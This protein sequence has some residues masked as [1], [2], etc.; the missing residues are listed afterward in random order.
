M[1]AFLL[2]KR[3]DPDRNAIS[4]AAPLAEDRVT[5]IKKEDIDKLE[6]LYSARKSFLLRLFDEPMTLREAFGYFDKPWK[7]SGYAKAINTW[8]RK[9]FGQNAIIKEFLKG[10]TSST[11]FWVL[12]LNARLF[13]VDYSNY[14]VK[15]KIED[16][17]N[18]GIR[19]IIRKLAEL[20][21]W[22]TFEELRQAGIPEGHIQRYI[23]LREKTSNK[24]ATDKGLP[25]VF[26]KTRTEPDICILN[27]VFAEAL[28]IK[29]EKTIDLE[30]MFSPLDLSIIRHL[31]E[32]GGA[33]PTTLVEQCNVSRQTIF[34]A[35][36][37]INERC[38]EFSL[39][40]AIKQIKIGQRRVLKVNDK[41]LKETGLSKPKN[42]KLSAFFS[43]KQ[44]NLIK[45][46]EEHPFSNTR[47]IASHL[48]VG[49]RATNLLINRINAICEK[50]RL[51]SLLK[52]GN[53]YALRSEFIT[54]FGLRRVIVEP[55][56]VL[57]AEEQ[58]KVYRYFEINRI[59]T[60]AQA[61]EAIGKS[62]R[63]TSLL[64]RSANHWL[65][66]A[67]FLPILPRKTA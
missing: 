52:S 48:G 61:A 7:V 50:E 9:R 23:I 33:T 25:P 29:I 56:I 44:I 3:A 18:G 40:T 53:T 67:G 1:R 60:L 45:F 5:K 59:A 32:T 43:S 37:R 51:P 64:I 36:K 12:K 49:L 63:A 21:G 66:Q 17:L 47:Q 41:F 46:L 62:Y 30:K 24:Q 15:L 27:P 6:G 34:Q 2:R 26:L 58:I 31:V 10:E 20:G 22:A 11:G 65:I 57:K 14:N 8:A 38:R 54:K 13:D 28:K 35:I 42:L 4:S 55:V 19:R 39:P 16:I